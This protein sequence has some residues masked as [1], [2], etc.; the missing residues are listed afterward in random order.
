MS[1]K[2]EKA[3]KASERAPSIESRWKQTRS[4]IGTFGGAIAL[5]LF[6][7]IV[8]VEAFEI[9]GPSMMPTL[10]NGDHVV[11][12]KFMYGLFLPF[13]HRALMTWNTPHA[14]QVV[15][16]NSPADDIDIV[17]RVI[18]VAGDEVEIREGVVIRNGHPI[19]KRSTGKRV[20]Q[21]EDD[22]AEHEI[23]EEELDGHPYHV[24]QAVWMPRF[25]M[26]PTKVPDGHI[27]VLGDHRDRSNDSRYI[28]PIPIERVKGRALAIYWS[29]EGDVR[30]DRLF[31]AV[32]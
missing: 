8:I 21:G 25:N 28:G 10:L 4:N 23:I 26:A 1:D 3:A 2:A 31:A 18:A 5:A 29:R 17:K 6:I 27:F 20:F 30:W 16:V 15:I 11:V 13:Q 32:E 24:S 9:E 19:A 22:A 7:R 12:A 14:G